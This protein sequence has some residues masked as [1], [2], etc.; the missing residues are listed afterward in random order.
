MVQ[1]MLDIKNTNLGSSK[2]SKEQN[3][4]IILNRA[5][6]KV[7]KLIDLTEVGIYR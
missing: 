6:V 2:I 4:E 1:K 7:L 5:F 3:K